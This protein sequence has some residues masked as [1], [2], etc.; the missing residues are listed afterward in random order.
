MHKHEQSALV[1]HKSDKHLEEEHQ[2]KLKV[3]E[4]DMRV[5]IGGEE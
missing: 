1:Y 4:A 2:L 5:V 3:N